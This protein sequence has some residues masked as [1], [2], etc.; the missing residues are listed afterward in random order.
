MPYMYMYMYCMCNKIW[1]SIEFQDITNNVHVTLIHT[2]THSCVQVHS[3]THLLYMFS[4][5]FIGFTPSMSSF[6]SLSSSL[7]PLYIYTYTVYIVMRLFSYKMCIIVTSS[8]S[9]P[10]SL[11]LPH[12]L[13]YIQHMYSVSILTWWFC[14]WRSRDRNYQSL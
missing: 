13:P 14:I 8:P 10:T 11:P 6:P 9:L 2:C 12:S 5:L 3:H 4:N 7:F 1:L